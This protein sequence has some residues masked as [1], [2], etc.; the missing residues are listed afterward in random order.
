M[1]KFLAE[2]NELDNYGYGL[3]TSLKLTWITLALV[4]FAYILHVQSYSVIIIAVLSCVVIIELP[5]I[6]S[7]YK[8]DL[9]YLFIAIFITGIY[10]IMSIATLMPIIIGLLLLVM[11]VFAILY[12]YQINKLLFMISCNGLL[13]VLFCFAQF[14]PHDNTVIINDSISLLEFFTLGFWLH[15]LYP[16]CYHKRWQQ[17]YVFALKVL[18]RAIDTGSNSDFFELRKVLSDLKNNVNLLNGN[19]QIHQAAIVMNTA[20]SHYSYFCISQVEAIGEF[21]QQFI[22]DVEQLR[23]AIAHSAPNDLV[24]RDTLEFHYIKINTITQHWNSI[25]KQIYHR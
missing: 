3:F 24:H 2:I 1:N 8:K 14:M 6:N 23:V 20:L 21:T 11:L 15:K 22:V 5:I 4:I 9:L 25:C 17:A 13:L 18:V 12:K 10:A 16:N 19:K 7:V